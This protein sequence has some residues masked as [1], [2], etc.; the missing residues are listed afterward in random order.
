MYEQ[1][2]V[3]KKAKVVTKI[4]Q[5]IMY[6][7]EWVSKDH[8]KELMRRENAYGIVALTLRDY[9]TRYALNVTR[10][11]NPSLNEWR[12]QKGLFNAPNGQV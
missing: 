6:A 11:K 10:V 5:K 3:S 7:Q 1:E 2:Q 12:H 4:S 9:L 8:F